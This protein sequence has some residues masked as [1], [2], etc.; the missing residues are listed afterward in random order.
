MLNRRDFIKLTGAVSL[1]PAASRVASAFPAAR[2]ASG[3]KRFFVM[4]RVYGGMDATLGLDAW[5]TP[6]AAPPDPKDLF[7]EYKDADLVNAGLP[8][9]LGPACKALEEHAGSF[10]VVNGVFLSQVDNGHMASLSYLSAG[11]TSG[12]APALPVEIAR[13]SEEGDLGVLTNSALSMGNRSALSSTLNDLRDLP[14]KSDV[15]GLLEKTSADRPTAFFEAVKRVLSSRPAL[16]T[17]VS[18]LKS[19]GEGDQVLDEQV[20]ASAFMSE[21]AY[22]AQLDIMK[23]P[24]DTHGQHPGTHLQNQALAW[25]DIAKMFSTFKNVPYGGKT[26]FDATTFM[27]M[28]EF[29][30]TP[31]LNSANGKD[32]NPL[33]NSVLLAGNG[34]RGGTVVGASRLVTGAESA[35]GV[36]YH[37][38]YPIDYASGEVQRERTPVAKMIFPE[39]VAMT[40]AQMMRVDLTHFRSVPPDTRPLQNLFAN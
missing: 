35:D 23:Y 40:V 32:H 6:E 21:V 15:S 1:L 10:A 29:S 14:N 26:L 24:L 7:I 12:L 19:F 34:V 33:T 28:T 16:Q 30:R 38:A 27:V 36:P 25:A 2:M 9:K 37:I 22:G 3:D 13:A 11:S 5:Q 39:N 8:I 4:V 31:A 18:N 17:F 20:I